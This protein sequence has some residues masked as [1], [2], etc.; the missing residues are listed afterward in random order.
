MSRAGRWIQH[1]SFTVFNTFRRRPVRSSLLALVVL[2]SLGCGGFYG[3]AVYSWRQAQ[4]DFKNKKYAEANRRLDFCR[5][6][7]PDHP[8]L[9]LLSAKTARK[10]GDLESAQLYLNRFFNT[11]PESR[12]EAQIETLLIR[13]QMGDDE[14]VEPLFKLVEQQ[15]PDSPAML[16]TISVTYMKRLRYQA[17]NGSLSKWIEL[18]PDQALPYDL[19]GWVYERTASPALAY[20]DYNKALAIDPSL[21]RVRLQLVGLLLEEK[22]VTE[23]APHLDILMKQAPDLVDVKARLGMLRYLEGR[24]QEARQLLE[25][26][27]PLLTNDFTPLVYLARLDVQ[28]NRG[29]DAERR[30]RKVIELDPTETDARFVILSALRL[31]GKDQEAAIAEKVQAKNQARNVRVNQLLRDRADKPDV[32]A[33]EWAEIGTLFLEMQMDARG[34]YWIDKALARDPNHQASHRVLM[35]HYD[36]KGDAVK[37]AFHRKLLR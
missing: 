22:K 35:E 17:A 37:S 16:E 6:V 29:A 7:W 5:Q 31:Q 33:D 11:K 28:E 1:K 34:L 3:W 10:S 25:T 30:L 13:V 2:A 12:D 8:S 4:A 27:E 26:V 20:E 32:T 21:Q 19:R 15:H 24:S 18:C 9:L 14:A 23:A 36:S